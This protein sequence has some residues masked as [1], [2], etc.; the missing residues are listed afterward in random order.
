[1][2]AYSTGAMTWQERL[3]G[4]SL[5]LYPRYLN[6]LLTQSTECCREAQ[7]HPPA[8]QM[9]SD[10]RGMYSLSTPTKFFDNLANNFRRPYSLDLQGH[11]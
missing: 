2:A 10:R 6:V 5:Q 7:L 8:F 1:M 11:H 9:F 3:D 4:T